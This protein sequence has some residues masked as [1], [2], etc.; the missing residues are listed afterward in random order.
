MNN[1]ELKIKEKLNNIYIFLFD[2]SDN[3]FGF[4]SLVKIDE[5][6]M[7]VKSI[8]ARKGYGKVLYEN[9]LMY[10]NEKECFI[11]SSRDGDTRENSLKRWNQIYEDESLN[12]KLIDEEHLEEIF[13]F[14]DIDTEPV[15]FYGYNKKITS[16]YNPQ[17]K[18]SDKE[19]NRLHKKSTE[20]FS[21]C[22]E[23]EDNSIIDKHYPIKKK[24][25]LKICYNK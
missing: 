4:A 20:I 15:F 14:A 10:G 7:E 21:I 17:Y 8:V 23:N 13:E 1:I 5:D 9:M 3:F 25:K 2:K 18:I 22:Y 16:D 11:C 12:K 6:L 24:Q 19:F